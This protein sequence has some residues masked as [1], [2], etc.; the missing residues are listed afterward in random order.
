MAVENVSPEFTL[1]EK[2]SAFKVVVDF[3]ASRS[4]HSNVTLPAALVDQSRAVRIKIGTVLPDNSIPELSV[5]SG[6]AGL[7]AALD[8][9]E[10]YRDHEGVAEIYN[11]FLAAATKH[12][13]Y[14][15]AERL[16]AEKN[17]FFYLDLKV[18]HI[19]ADPNDIWK[20]VRQEQDPKEHMALEK[21]K[22]LHLLSNILGIPTSVMVGI[23]TAAHSTH[24]ELSFAAIVAGVLA[25]FVVMPVVT[26]E[27]AKN[28]RES[29]T[30][31]FK[32]ER[33]G[34]ADGEMRKHPADRA[35]EEWN[36]TVGCNEVPKIQDSKGLT[37]K[38]L[39]Y[40][41]IKALR[42]KIA[43]KVLA[44]TEIARD[45][46]LDIQELTSTLDL[47]LKTAEEMA[48]LP[49]LT[50]GPT[51]ERLAAD[52]ELRVLGVRNYKQTT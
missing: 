27:L 19:E 36:K 3:L 37:E 5:G 49:Q 25:A 28:R 23:V 24:S 4:E 42:D 9:V 6:Y 51:P 34:A 2:I 13:E 39:Q 30:G 22:N 1:E 18:P 45:T 15:L 29:V 50:N 11:E 8:T 40:V 33:Q 52:E 7:K 21:I 10:Q 31:T 47:A 12:I 35:L 43:V 44:Q 38:V 17:A 16:K 46:D 32:R 41:R 48:T 20:S 14:V 26:G